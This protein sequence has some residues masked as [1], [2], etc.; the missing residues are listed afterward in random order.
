MVK[1]KKEEKV[2]FVEVKGGMDFMKV[3]WSGIAFK[4]KEFGNFSFSPKLKPPDYAPESYDVSGEYVF[5][6]TFKPK[7]KR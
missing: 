7:G 2:P 4:T 6:I 3:S 1:E 5:K